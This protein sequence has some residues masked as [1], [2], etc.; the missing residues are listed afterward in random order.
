MDAIENGLVAVVKED[1]QTCVMIEP[2]LA[3]LATGGMAV[4]SQDNPGF[5]ASVP[6]VLD[7]RE[8]E[9][10][11]N[12][13]IETVPTLVRYE[14][15]LETGRLVG[16]V[17]DEWQDF[18]GITDLGAELPEFRPGCGSK[19]VEPG[20]AEELAVRYGDLAIN[21]RR[22]EVAPLEDEIE[23]CFDREWSDGLPVVPPTPT[24]VYRM[25][26]GTTRAPDEVIGIIPPDLAPCT[27]EKV[28]INAVMAGCKPEY[29][30]VVLAA[31]EAALIDEFCMH[32]LLCTTMFA[33]P[34]VVV[35]GPIARKIGMNAREN[36]LGQG[37]RANATIGRALQLVIRNVG[38]GKPGGIDRA[39]L[40]NPGKYT[41]CFA[42]DEEG[43]Q[44]DSL[45][46]ERGFEPD[47]ST[48]TLFA[49]DG[50]QAIAD[51]KSRTPESLSRTLAA[52]LRIVDH[53]KMVMAG[54]AFLVVSPEH[55]RVFNDA[56]WSKARLKQELDKLLMIPGA[57][58]VAGAGGIAEG[59]PASM[60]D[61]TLPKFR[62][63]GLNIV[64]AGGGAGMFS[65]V[66]GGWAATGEI[67]SI[68]VTKEITL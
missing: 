63:G 62:P 22:I 56:G 7:D 13:E 14:N 54:D 55:E 43:S 25:L 46:V 4:Y 41:F 58:L 59:L 33:G 38:G 5:P 3:Q 18:T 44:W 30:P 67:G 15:G 53:P 64:R 28:A 39:C 52:C 6:S 16:W 65:A 26:Q 31:V 51:Q 12:L 24:R 34:M 47:V 1:C 9:T 50:V 40:G 42:E 2:V 23:A 20:I 8:L 48:V 60:A 37:N 10:S 11:F 27:V 29:L 49:A 68:P 21:A 19:S 57:E 36:A 61:K 17:R 66:I 45:A 32:G 35:N